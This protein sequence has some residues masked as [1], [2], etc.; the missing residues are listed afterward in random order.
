MQWKRPSSFAPKNAK[1][2]SSAGRTGTIFWHMKGTV[3]IDYPQKNATSAMESTVLTEAG[4][5]GYQD[6]VSRK[7]DKKE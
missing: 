4:M 2:V 3:L 6:Q 1:V 7:T 5:K